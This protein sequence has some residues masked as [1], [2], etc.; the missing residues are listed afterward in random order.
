MDL[1][2][3]TSL[4][5]RNL[6]CTSF[7]FRVSWANFPWC[8]SGTPVLFRTACTTP[9]RALPVTADQVLATDAECGSSTRGHWDGP[10]TCNKSHWIA[11]REPA[12]RKVPCEHDASPCLGQAT[13]CSGC[14]LTI[15]IG[16]LGSASAK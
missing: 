14:A 7:P 3:Y 2:W 16:S 8:L 15:L 5:T 12:G 13:V 1:V 9:L 4:T 11:A 6:S 10:V